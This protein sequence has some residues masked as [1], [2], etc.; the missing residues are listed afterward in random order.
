[1]EKVIL[2]INNSVAIV[3]SSYNGEK[4]ISEQIDSILHQTH[5]EWQLIIRDD[6]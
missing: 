5:K 4:Y 6:G 3:L 1:M 2:V